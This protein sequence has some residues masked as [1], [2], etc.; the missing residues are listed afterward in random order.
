[1]EFSPMPPEGI[2]DL[3]ILIARGN[4]VFPE[5][6]KHVIEEALINPHMIAFGTVASVATTCA[7][8]PTTVVRAVNMLGFRN[9]RDFRV[10][11]QR[12]LKEVSAQGFLVDRSKSSLT[13]GRC[14]TAARAVARSGYQRGQLL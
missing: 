13:A 14:R 3:K 2:Q 11:F 5:A 8:S 4:I 9:F 7:V 6:Q 12:H 1:M 10:L